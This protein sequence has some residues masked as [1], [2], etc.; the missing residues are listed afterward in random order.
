VL[1]GTAV[2]VR[3]ADSDA[4]V[5][6][7]HHAGSALELRDDDTTP[8]AFTALLG[9]LRAVGVDGWLRAMPESVVRPEAAAI[10]EMLTGI[11]IPPGFDRAALR[12]DDGRVRDRYQLGARVVGA[13]ACAWIDRWAGAR[14]AGDVA[15][16]RAAT[17]AMATAR[18]WPVLLEMD[19]EGDYLEVLREVAAAMP[20]D[21]TV[22]GGRPISL[23]SADVDALGCPLL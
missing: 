2:V 5:A 11:P 4:Y 13:V 7:W 18:A 19:A 3:Y 9:S 1:G 20:N 16:A 10:D 21:G 17:E 14:R 12:A 15:G 8:E 23:E 22:P 6:M